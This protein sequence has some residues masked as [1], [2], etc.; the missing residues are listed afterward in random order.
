MCGNGA[1]V[2]WYGMCEE[3]VQVSSVVH[4]VH[5]GS[6]SVLSCVQANALFVYSSLTIDL[7]FLRLESSNRQCCRMVR[8]RNGNSP[9]WWI[10]CHGSIFDWS[11]CGRFDCKIMSDW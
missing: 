6:L 1:G 9:P 4:A 10:M 2:V 8:L 11:I 7:S 5:L 3:H